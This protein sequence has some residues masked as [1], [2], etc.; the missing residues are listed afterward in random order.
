MGGKH[1]A[2]QRGRAAGA[3][4]RDRPRRRGG[5]AALGRVGSPAV[6]SAQ[7]EVRARGARR[8]SDERSLARALGAAEAGR[9]QSDAVR[10]AG[11]G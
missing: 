11:L 6:R 9:W 2:A 8:G 5:S 1:Q 7:F 10:M 3:A 4:P